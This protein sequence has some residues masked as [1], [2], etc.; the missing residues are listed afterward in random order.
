MQKNC[1]VIQAQKDADV[2]ITKTTIKKFAW[3]S[4]TLIGEDADLLVVLLFNADLSKCIAHY[5]RTEKIKYNVYNIK[6]LKQILGKGVCNAPLF[7]YAY[8]GY[9]VVSRIQCSVQD[10]M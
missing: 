9:N 5:F 2:C 3:R 7:L 6:V 4:V 10:A 8:T 1:N